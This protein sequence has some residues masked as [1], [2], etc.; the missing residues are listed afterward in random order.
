MSWFRRLWCRIFKCKPPSPPSGPL[1][2]SRPGLLMCYFGVQDGQMAST[3]A[4]VNAA[5]IGSWGDWSSVAG[6]QQLT[7]TM[8]RYAKEAIANG[9]DKLIFTL[10]WC[11]LTPTNPRQLLP[12]ATATKYLIEFCD[13]LTAEGLMD[14]VI[15][16]YPVD[17]PNIPEIALSAGDIYITNSWIRNVTCHY[18]SGGVP[19]QALPLVCC[20]GQSNGVYP[21]IGS[22]DWVSFDNYGN[23]I[24]ANG[25]YQHLVDQ[26]GP[27]Q[28]TFLV[29]GGSNPWRESP[30][31]YYLHAQGDPR[32]VMIVPFAWFPSPDGI[33]FNGMQPA[34]DKVGDLIKAGG[35]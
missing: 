24:F 19:A 28:R 30:D 9:V 27:S 20:Y 11:V 4:H 16:W 1:P 12:E 14:F 21:G 34:Y 2:P 17:E 3:G 22:Y 23:D 10:D 31:P 26:L 32:V 13:R 33:G 18:T 25:W 8:V 15:G 5:H 6:R 35:V 29:A 7:D